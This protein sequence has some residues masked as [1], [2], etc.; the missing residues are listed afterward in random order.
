MTQI[1]QRSSPSRPMPGWPRLGNPFSLATIGPALVVLP[2][3][4]AGLLGFQ[5]YAAY[6]TDAAFGIAVGAVAVV[7]MGQT[8]ILAARPRWLEPIFGGL[9]RMYRVHKWLG[10]AALVLMILHNSAEPDFDRNVRETGMGELASDMG[11]LAFN[12]MLGL[13]AVSWFRRLPFIKLEIPYQIWRL[14]HRLMGALFAMV[15]FHQ[16]FVDM[17]TGVDPTLSVLLN[18]FGVAGVIAWLYTELVAPHLRRRDYVVSQISVTGATTTVTLEPTGR[19]MRWRPGQFAFLR[20]PAAGMAEPHPFTIASAP[21]DDGRLTLSIRALGG[22][23]R[24]LPQKLRTGMAVQ[25]DG[26]YGRFDFRQGGQRQL[27]L[28]GG[29]GI[30]PFLAWAESLTGDEARDIHLIHCV[31]TADEAIGAETLAAAAARNPRFRYQVIVTDRDGRLTA[32]RLVER[33]TFPMRTADLWFCGPTGLKDSI[34]KGLAAQGQTP[35]RVRF[36]HFDFA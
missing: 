20:A 6:G 1:M 14:S 28:A 29:I 9:D 2:C 3:L 18:G 5:T 35:R 13:I 11:E 19:A 27:W 24:R 36:E 8:L 15:V 31:R 4:L 12:A 25:I 17:P 32:D 26:P 34:L 7:A 10:I 16:F 22:W 30:T 23:T 33:A 21:R